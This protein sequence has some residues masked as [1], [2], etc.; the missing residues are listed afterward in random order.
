MVLSDF[1]WFAMLVPILI[2]VNSLNILYRTR[3]RR[4][5]DKEQREIDLKFK[6]VKRRNWTYL[7]RDGLE[8]KEITPEELEEEKEIRKSENQDFSVVLVLALVIALMVYFW[9]G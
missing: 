9:M 1:F 7:Q 6:D 8:P 2:V 4:T 5:I 3:F